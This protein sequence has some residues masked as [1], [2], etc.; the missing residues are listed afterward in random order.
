[1][2]KLV[3]MLRELDAIKIGPD[4]TVRVWKVSDRGNRQVH[5]T[6][7]APGDL[8]I[9]REHLRGKPAPQAQH[10]YDPGAIREQLTR[11]PRE[12][13]RNDNNKGDSND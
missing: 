10:D 12:E 1:M 4:I 11:K 3:V 8:R 6:V 13:S 5:L 9:S 2:G 7:E